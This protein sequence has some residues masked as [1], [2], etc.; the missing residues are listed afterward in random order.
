M[1]VPN[2]HIMNKQSAIFYSLLFLLCCSF[3]KQ[4]NEEWKEISNKFYSITLPCH[5]STK[6]EKDFRFYPA[7]QQNENQ[8][9]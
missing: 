9:Q 5:W 7:L 4:H 1:N 3:T 8:I 6:N 2:Y